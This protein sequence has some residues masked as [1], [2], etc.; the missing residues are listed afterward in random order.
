MSININDN[1]G[2]RS[3]DK[4]KSFLIQA[5]MFVQND[6]FVNIEQIRSL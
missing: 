5:L 3:L 4:Y 2:Q 6:E 1:S